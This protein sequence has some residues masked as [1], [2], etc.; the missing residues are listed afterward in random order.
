MY[1]Y[2][3]PWKILTQSILY[4]SWLYHLSN[5]GKNL[6]MKYEISIKFTYCY[7]LAI[8]LWKFF[9]VVIYGSNEN[10][11]WESA[12][13]N[14]QFLM[15]FVFTRTVELYT[16]SIYLVLFREYSSIYKY[17]IC[18]QLTVIFYHSTEKVVIEYSVFLLYV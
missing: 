3:R 7:I 12:V 17:N 9:F 18:K 5:N 15:S 13:I 16:L 2:V 1:M 8:F 6:T 4:I 11:G 10:S 14:A